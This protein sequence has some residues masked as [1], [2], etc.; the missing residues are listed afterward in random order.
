MDK[1]DLEFFLTNL[2]QQIGLIPTADLEAHVE[3]CEQS[4][5]QFDSIGVMLDPT[6][7]MQARNT[8]EFDMAKGRNAMARH[9]L[10][11]R[12]LMDADEAL[13]QEYLK[14]TGQ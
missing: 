3:E 10:E 4:V 11:I 7:W 5:R 2:V 8:G 9:I 1:D 6:Y 13:R 14:K 12:K